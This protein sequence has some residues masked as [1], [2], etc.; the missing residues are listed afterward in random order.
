MHWFK[1]FS[2][3]IKSPSDIG[4]ILPSSRFLANKIASQVPKNAH[5]IVEL[6]AGTGAITRKLNE[7]PHKN[8]VIFERNDE[9]CSILK[10]KF[11]KAI[12]INDSA[13]HLHQYTNK[14]HWQIDAVVSS[15]PMLNFD[16]ILKSRI[17]DSIFTV[18]EHGGR[19]VQF[20]Y[21]NKDPLPQKDATWRQHV[22]ITTT[23]VWLNL[24][25][26]RIWCL[27][28]AP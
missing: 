28:F 21:G 11:P 3:L 18:L 23:R 6:G 14:Y 2:N 7:C 15:L 27:T 13:E 20:T 22:S 5:T 17:C 19:M 4:A 26:A 16:Y 24:P 25:P 1:F 9:F 12:I 8:L 10:R